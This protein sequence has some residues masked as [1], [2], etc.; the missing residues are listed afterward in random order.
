MGCLPH[1][2]LGLETLWR[3]RP[4]PSGQHIPVSDHIHSE[5]VIL[6]FKWYFM[7]F[8]LCPLSP[9]RKVWLRFFFWHP[10]SCLSSGLLPC[11]CVYMD[12]TPVES[13]LLQTEQGPLLCFH[14][15]YS[16]FLCFG[17]VRS[18]L[19]THAGLLPP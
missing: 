14:H 2:Q 12:K 17:F 1:V 8:S 11:P 13:F 4:Y 6:M 9:L 10:V 18:Y 16:S 15:L 19:F 7:C 3:W 5:K